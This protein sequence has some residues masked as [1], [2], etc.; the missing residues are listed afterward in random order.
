MILL[1]TN[2]ISEL[3]RQ[4]PDPAVVA[5]LRTLAPDGVFTAAIC[6]AESRYGLAR[7]PAGHGRDQ[8]V[9]RIDDLFAS[10]F[11]EQVVP[12]DG[13]CAAI[14]GEIRAS[15][16]A[17]GKP[18]AVEDAMVAATARAHGAA[19]ATRNIGDFVECGTIIVNPWDA[20]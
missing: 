14:Y 20:E 3:V 9:A 13:A 5:Y 4:A 8:L 16:E 18:I 10:G 12:F 17:A 11:Q 2:V 19:L 1:D 7:M 6:E 15:R